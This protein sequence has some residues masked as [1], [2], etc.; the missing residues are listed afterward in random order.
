MIFPLMQEDHVNN[1]LSLGVPPLNTDMRTPCQVKVTPRKSEGLE[2][3]SMVNSP[4][5]QVEVLSLHPINTPSGQV[6][7]N[8][9][10]SE[11]IKLFTLVNSLPGQV[12]AMS[13][14]PIN[15]TL[16]QVGVTPCN[17]EGIE[18]LTTSTLHHFKSGSPLTIQKASSTSTWSTLCHVKLRQCP[19]TQSTLHQVL[20]G[21]HL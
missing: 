17:P 21:S 8:P 3:F 9:C 20:L 7:V 12:E 16:G 1:H 5:C 14:H 4:P 18:P 19:H 2:P 13:S 11:G 10:K 6:G 15:T